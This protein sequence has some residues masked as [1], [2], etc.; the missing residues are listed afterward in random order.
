MNFKGNLVKSQSKIGKA[1]YVSEKLNAS[2]NVINHYFGEVCF[3][4]NTN[5]QK[6][7]HVGSHIQ[8]ECV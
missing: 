3:T 4:V 5:T 7:S 1:K 8:S 6:I 2:N